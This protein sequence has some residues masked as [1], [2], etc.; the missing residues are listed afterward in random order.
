MAAVST[1]GQPETLFN[2]LQV[3]LG[4]LRPESDS[5]LEELQQARLAALSS[6]R[7]GFEITN[8]APN[9]DQPQHVPQQTL[10]ELAQIV[11]SAID[12]SG[13][14]VQRRA[15]GRGPL[16]QP[17][18]NGREAVTRSLGP[19]LDGEHRPVIL[20]VITPIPLVGI[21]WAGASQPF[22]FV[23]PASAS[24]TSNAMTL[25]AG[26][27]WIASSQFAAGSPNPSFIG[28]SI[29][30]GTISFGQTITMDARPIIVPNAALVELV[31]ETQPNG[32]SSASPSKPTVSV[33]AK[34][35]FTFQNSGSAAGGALTAADDMSVSFFGSSKQFT[36]QSAS[37]VLI[38]DPP[39][40]EFLFKPE[41]EQ[42]VVN[43]PTSTIAQFSGE[44]SIKSVAWSLNVTQENANVLAQASGAGS[45]S[46][47]LA[48]GLTASVV[49]GRS[50][51]CGPCSLTVDSDFYSIVGTSGTTLNVPWP[52]TPISNALITARTPKPFEYAY[53]QQFSDD[54]EMFEL[55]LSIDASFDQPRTV[56]G[57][58]ILVIGSGSCTFSRMGTSKQTLIDGSPVTT[59]SSPLSY[60]YALKNTLL[61]LSPPTRLEIT[62]VEKNGSR[63]QASINMFSNLRTAIPFLPDPYVTNTDP[64]A[65]QSTRDASAMVVQIAVSFPTSTANAQVDISFIQA[66]SDPSASNL[67]SLLLSNG[68][69]IQ[70]LASFSTESVI[71][72]S[73][74]FWLDVSSSISQFG[75][76]LAA[77]G[78]STDSTTDTAAQV[79]PEVTDLMLNVDNRN[80][81]VA[82]LPIIQWEP[83]YTPDPMVFLDSTNQTQPFPS[84]LRYSD[85]GP[86]TRFSTNSATLVP[87][88]PR[89]AIDSLIDGWKTQQD[90]VTAVFTL[91]FGMIAQATLSHPILLGF[92][93]PRLLQ[94]QPSFKSSVMEGGDQISILGVAPRRL[95]IP[96]LVS[97]AVADSASIPGTAQQLQNT[98]ANTN[99]PL[100]AISS[101]GTDVMT[102]A[103][104]DT[105][106]SDQTGKI[107]V[108][109]VDISG[110][111]A[112]MF[113]DW[114]KADTNSETAITKVQF[115]VMVGRTAREV[116]QL[117]SVLHWI[118]KVKLVRTIT[119]E[120]LNSGVVVRHDSNWQPASDGFFAPENVTHAGIVAAVNSITN[121]RDVNTGP[122]VTVNNPGD[123][124]HPI[125]LVAVMFDCMLQVQNAVAGSTSQGTPVRDAIGYV[126]TTVGGTLSAV[127]FTQLLSNVGGSLGGGID[128]TARIG[129]SGQLMR[130]QQV[131]IA[132]SSPPTGDNQFCIATWGSPV[133]PG[134]GQWSF[135]TVS[136][137]D[138]SPKAISKNGVPLII[139]G[140][141]G[142]MPTANSPFRFSDPS[143]LFKLT[144]PGVNYCLC[145]TTGSQ[146]LL[147]PRPIIRPAAPWAVTTDTTGNP[148]LADPFALGTSTGPFPRFAVCIPFLDANYQ[149]FISASG[150]FKLQ[151][152]PNSTSTSFTLPATRRIL[153]SSDN[154]R[155]VVFSGDDQGHP[156][157]VD[158]SIDTSNT[159]L[160]WSFSLQ[161]FSL[162]SE[163]PTFGDG[164]PD[165][166]ASS[167]VSRIIG[168]I[169]S[170]PQ[171]GTQVSRQPTFQFGPAMKPVKEALAFLDQFGLIPPLTIHMTNEWSADAFI[172]VQLDKD[173]FGPLPPIFES[174]ELQIRFSQHGLSASADFGL[175]VRLKFGKPW[176]LTLMGQI[177]WSLST[178]GGSL[179]TLQLGAG[180][181]ADFGFGDFK[182]FGSVEFTIIGMKGSHG[183][184]WGFSLLIT[185]HIDWRLISL[186]VDIEAGHMSMKTLCNNGQDETKWGLV[187][188]TV[189]IDLHLCF[190]VDIDVTYHTEKS[191][192]YNGGRCNMD[193]QDGGVM[194]IPP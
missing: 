83:V 11:A 119:I 38:D 93:S 104:N 114:R 28:L 190:I 178:D 148:L 46:M 107:P 110:F 88:N 20:D 24:G 18:G 60:H 49:D 90:S 171:Q 137:G 183:W 176:V 27:V 9:G 101:A 109:R 184:G 113:S 13:Q 41:S 50:V 112:S 33:P 175:K 165:P 47:T 118:V 98:L 99:P 150:D 21:Q 142:Q 77:Q 194:G 36:L 105:F 173:E 22:L 153:A 10:A 48:D 96:Q 37:P 143:D 177:A 188:A 180:A 124:T 89:A 39:R 71:N 133:F 32:I 187:Q 170:D 25:G 6:L 1:L 78:G 80:V 162:I 141:A 151:L 61:E 17:L 81:D 72:R 152:E 174:F 121:I 139:E 164:Q 74:P 160:P 136:A 138:D 2:S 179:F 16:T 132:A 116:I 4:D 159:T 161:N 157:T 34:A 189:A 163:C 131:T 91:P 108:T 182:A 70:P 31:V 193:I 155:G 122:P 167:E 156:A 79:T 19:F 82:A 192:K 166:I 172:D 73:L 185:V 69:L 158:I 149:L 43:T 75:L 59:S 5:P 97:P 14:R 26:S 7:S 147:L 45:L 123:P 23:D 126:Q 95:S 102:K 120:R 63:L 53:Q 30:S 76:G 103:F 125:Q 65:V 58:R 86:I 8:I 128:C 42:F 191:E 154:H 12:R 100:T 144:N 146:K 68:N 168:S 117:A 181:G 84:P 3:A 52:I 140:P 62:V 29:Q 87:F 134:G 51:K 130:L 94:V 92:P 57:A 85:S 135:L 44:M 55:I 56:D 115:D 145:H 67:R 15:I 66:T 111:G 35:T 186:E 54:T 64:L 40:I 106:N 127:Q 169:V 129:G